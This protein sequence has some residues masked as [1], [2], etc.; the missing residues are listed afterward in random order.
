M[1]K[2]SNRVVV[3]YMGEEKIVFLSTSINGEEQHWTTS[4]SIFNASGIKKEDI[5]KTE[6]HFAF[7]SDL[8]KSL[9]D[10]NIKNEE[11]FVLR[12]HPGNFRMK[13][14]FEEYVRLHR[15]FTSFSNVDIWEYLKDK[16]DINH[17]LERVPDEFDKWVKETI[18]NLRY[19]K[20][21]IEERAGKTHDYFRYGKYGDRETEPTKKEFAE[22]LEFC[23]VEPS[24][25]SI[26][27]A[28]WDG[29]AYD[30][31]IWK[32]VKPKYQKPFWNKK[33]EIPADSKWIKRD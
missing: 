25:R 2:I 10:K 5:V 19:H 33:E 24:I 3:D 11:G 21:A 1:S 20:Y 31:I 28:I 13:I 8:Y 18:S 9:K 15:L 17:L 30:H 32:I 4:L 6:Q 23:K 29:K 26:C 7:G 16:K 12:F 27:F 22:H 14:K